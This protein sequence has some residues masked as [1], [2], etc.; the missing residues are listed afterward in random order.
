M[1]WVQGPALPLLVLVW[2]L[3]LGALG[4]VPGVRRHA[5]RL[6]V[7]A[8]LPAL[9]LV[10]TGLT[11]GTGM[12]TEIPYL[13]L[14][15]TLGAARPALLLLGLTAVL[16]LATGIYAQVY[17]EKA[18]NRPVFAAFWCLTF[19]G[20]IGVFLAQDVASFY[21]SFATV[22]L[23]AYFLVIQDRRPRAMHAGRIYIVLAILG[24]A[25]L[26]LAFLIGS[27]AA[28][29]FL[30]ADVRAALATAPLGAVA[31]G[32]L[33]FGFG[34][35]AGLMPL[36]VWLPLAHPAAPVPASAVLSGAIVKAGI[37]GLILFLPVG[38]AGLGTA[39][40]T[41]G[42][43]GAYAGI[44]LGLTQSNPKT[45]LA[46]STIS[47]IGLIIATVGASL[48]GTIGAEATAFQAFHHGLAK[49]ALFL[50]VGLLAASGRGFFWPVL[51]LTGFAAASISGMPLT[52]GALAKAAVTSGFEGHA[53]IA[54][55]FS[56]FASA[57][58]MVRFLVVMARTW[59]AVGLAPPVL[60]VLPWL[61]LLA[62]A[63]AGPWLMWPSWTGLGYDAVLD[64]KTLWQ[65][66]WPV[67][68]GVIA[69]FLAVRMRMRA[70]K[71][72]EGDIIVWLEPLF[73][74]AAVLLRF[75]IPQP[76][77]T[78]PAW[79]KRIG[80][81]IEAVLIR[82]QIAGLAVL[83]LVLLVVFGG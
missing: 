29:S 66:A 31:A 41:V 71:I 6:I 43:F 13:L 74:Q 81:V 77:V 83:A 21:L 73:S 8:P 75:R 72:P 19:S 80:P 53:Y 59:Q 36:H 7:L 57:L 58:L 40:I 15:V 10:Q 18:R 60:M 44:G 49:G 12:T 42:I 37:I 55:G 50:S 61:V 46:Y 27:S 64:A 56:G 34:M 68:L 4:L 17:M 39:L 47:Q 62:S 79:L 45:I 32:L 1:N 69:A 38:W 20:N 26:L 67:L 51:V 23:A 54:L 30:I 70:P 16:W 52:G 2:P 24:E 63:V 76:A 25:S 14:G 5:L 3:F 33:V 48:N 35:K 28:D 78:L 65:G 9:A 82:W 22:S 11:R